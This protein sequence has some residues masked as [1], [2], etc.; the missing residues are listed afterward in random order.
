VAYT[1]SL[2]RQ[3]TTGSISGG[4]NFNVDQ[5]ESIGLVTVD[6]DDE[7]NMGVF[8]SYGRPLFSDR[9]GFNS[10]LRYEFNNGETDWERFTLS[11]GLNVSF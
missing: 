7:Q 9:I 10:S 8:L 4:L 11:A 5:Y 3:L 2:S 1:T 6:R